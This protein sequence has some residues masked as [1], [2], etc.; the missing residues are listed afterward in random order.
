VVAVGEFWIEAVLADANAL[1]PGEGLDEFERAVFDLA[2][3]AHDVVYDARPGDDERASAAW[4]RKHLLEAG[5]DEAVT[6]RVEQLVLTTLN[7]EFDP[8]D[9]VAAVLS[10]ADL[11]VLA[12]DPDAHDGYA[13]AVGAEFAAVP[14]DLWAVGRR[15]VLDQLLAKARLF[16][17]DE[18]WA[19]WEARARD[20]MRREL[21]T[22]AGS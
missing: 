14:D 10:D 6:E 9:R 20:N 13:H 3:C 19:R 11:S 7:H 1:A 8:D 18:G 15:H 16:V 22:L 12:I 17:T 5:V 21:A 4:A 2:V